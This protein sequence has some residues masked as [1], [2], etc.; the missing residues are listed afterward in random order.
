MLA[1]MAIRCT[2]PACGATFNVDEKHAGKRG[3][4]GKCATVFRLPAAEV[5]VAELV[6]SLPAPAALSEQ[7]ARDFHTKVAGVT[8]QNRDGSDRQT[9]IRYCEVGEP[10]TLRREPSNRYDRKAVAVDRQTGEQIGYLSAELAADVAPWIDQGQRVEAEISSL[11]GGCPGESFGVNLRVRMYSRELPQDSGGLTVQ[12][13][14]DIALA[15]GDVPRV[16]RAL[17]RRPANLVDR[18]FNFLSVV[19]TA[20]SNRKES[21]AMAE[22]CEQAAWLHIG[23]FPKL[24]KA[25][26]K[27]FDGELPRVPTFRQLATLL[28]EQQRF[29]KAIEVCQQAIGFGLFD[30]MQGGFEGRIERIR[31]KQSR[32]AKPQRGA[33]AK[34]EGERQQELI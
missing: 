20:Y 5:I 30:G 4:C 18:H 33:T 26:R 28:T 1:G 34:G 25:L 19:G 10:L 22:L 23:E 8:Q 3:R 12:Q 6:E 14:L 27:F 13:E 9:I 17:Q 21:T 15:S 24:A 31:R 7:P 11:T 16:F 2:C 32:P 29:D